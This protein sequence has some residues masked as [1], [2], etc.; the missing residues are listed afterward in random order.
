MAASHTTLV[1]PESSSGTRAAASTSVKYNE[2]PLSLDTKIYSTNKSSEYE[3][4]DEMKKVCYLT[5]ISDDS[6]N[7]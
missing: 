4:E 7:C 6:G 3:D 2:F 1:E 5:P